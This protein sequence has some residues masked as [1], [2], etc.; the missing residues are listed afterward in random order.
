MENNQ[1]FLVLMYQPPQTSFKKCPKTYCIVWRQA[2]WSC[3]PNRSKR[4]CVEMDVN[5]QSTSCQQRGE[6]GGDSMSR[7]WVLLLWQ[8][9]V[10]LHLV[11]AE[12]RRPIMAMVLASLNSI[13]ANMFTVFVR[14]KVNLTE[15]L[16]KHLTHKTGQLWASNQTIPHRLVSCLLYRR[17]WWNIIVNS[18]SDFLQNCSFPTIVSN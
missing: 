12:V 14:M 16:P 5:N 15:R 2:V 18:D 1:F 8:R 10:H 9:P 6:E 11:S 13:V 7:A 4:K 3:G 17:E